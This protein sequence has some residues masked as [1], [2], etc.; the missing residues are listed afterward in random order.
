MVGAQFITIV[1][2]CMKLGI[3][4]AMR[5]EIDA[6]I[7]QFAHGYRIE[8]AGMRTYYHG[9][10]FGHQVV[11][12]FSRWG[13]VA[14][15]TTATHIIVHDHIDHLLFTGVAGAVSPDLHIGDVI[16]GTRL[17]QHDMDARPLFGR[18]EIPLLG[19]NSFSTDT[20]FRTR[21]FDAMQAFLRGDTHQVVYGA[22]ATGD[23][24]FSRKQD[25]EELRGGLPDVVC[26][27]MEG[28]AVAQVCYEHQI[29]FAVV[30]TISDR[31]D[32]A[33]PIDFVRFISEV[34][35]HYSHAIITSF[36]TNYAVSKTVVIDASNV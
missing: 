23:K 15:A 30:R 3:I 19:V 24:F 36:L 14:S 31:A 9:A 21:S 5:E 27:E 18:Y 35:R 25:L 7:P 20:A 32:H 28:A 34:A 12:S 1:H 29:P 16:I 33:A 8:E 22:I 4:S 6:L 26:V 10:L 11:L 17:Y 2:S 13:K